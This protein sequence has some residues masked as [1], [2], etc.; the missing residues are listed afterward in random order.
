MRRPS[1]LYALRLELIEKH[2]PE[3][4]IHYIVRRRKLTRSIAEAAPCGARLRRAWSKLARATNSKATL[5]SLNIV[6]RNSAPVPCRHLDPTPQLHPRRP[7]DIQPWLAD[8]NAIADLI[9]QLTDERPKVDPYVNWNHPWGL[10]ELSGIV[11]EHLLPL[12]PMISDKT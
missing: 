6:L 12:T 3:N 11:R 7:R 9:E 5:D 10:P 4:P 1:G 8:P 2:L